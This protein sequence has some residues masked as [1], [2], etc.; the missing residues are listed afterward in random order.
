MN[1]VG[2]INIVLLLFVVPSTVNC[3]F[4]QDVG[5]LTI[6]RNLSCVVNANGTMGTDYQFCVVRVYNGTIGTSTTVVPVYSGLRYTNTFLRYLQQNCPEYQT[7]P[8]TTVSGTCTS[9]SSFETFSSM[10]F[11]ICATDS[12]NKNIS[13]CEVSIFSLGDAP[14]PTSFIPSLSTFIPCNHTYNS[15]IICTEQPF[16]NSSLC[17]DYVKNNSVLCAISSSGTQT[18]QTALVG[19]D[20]E[21]YL[22]EK[23]YQLRSLNANN[24][25]NSSYSETTNIAYY[26]YASATTS[27]LQECVCTNLSYCNYNMTTC[28]PQNAETTT[29]TTITTTP[30][31][32]TT[33]TS[34]ISANA[35]TTLATTTAATNATTTA[36]TVSANATTTLATTTAATNATTTASTVSANAT[37]LTTTSTRTSTSTSTSTSSSVGQQ[38]LVTGET[39][40]GR[41][42][43]AGLVCGIIF[44]ALLFIGEVLF[45]KFIFPRFSGPT[46][47]ERSVTYQ[48]S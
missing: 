42:A 10:R 44:S 18:I 45:F 16:I 41:S 11:C 30:A 3:F 28:A 8:D 39:G 15:S 6:L 24:G 21:R 5:N 26:T 12:C 9:S 34:T 22:S 23:V 2:W 27:L 32:F 38:N 46:G 48:S 47:A 14:V 29:T 19:I 40:L 20:Y 31:N 17:D 4:L 33:A 43:T 13:T 36:S 1:Q 37:A 7:N 25:S 35:T